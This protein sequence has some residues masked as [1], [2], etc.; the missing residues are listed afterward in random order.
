[1]QP[2]FKNPKVLQAQSPDVVSREK[3]LRVVA[4]FT[5]NLQNFNVKELTTADFELWREYS[6]RNLGIVKIKAALQATNPDLP[7]SPSQ[8]I[9]RQALMEGVTQSI[10]R[11]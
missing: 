10:D 7:L 6:E 5:N 9:F 3:I 2:D 11:R 4:D 1:M 8:I